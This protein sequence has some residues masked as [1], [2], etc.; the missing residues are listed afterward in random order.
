MQRNVTFFEEWSGLN[1]SYFE[2]QILNFDIIFE[3]DD[4]VDEN[5]YNGVLTFME[6]YSLDEIICISIQR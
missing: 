3:D 1:D 6:R 5:H 2:I 4:F